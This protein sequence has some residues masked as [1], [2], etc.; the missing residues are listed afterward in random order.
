M[1]KLTTL[2]LLL[3]SPLV[4][5]QDEKVIFSCKHV[6]GVASISVILHLEDEIII[7]VGTDLH[8]TVAWLDDSHIAHFDDTGKVWAWFGVEDGHKIRPA[9]P[10]LGGTLGIAMNRAEVHLDIRRFER[11]VWVSTY[12]ED[13]SFIQ[14][15]LYDNCIN[16]Q[17]L[18]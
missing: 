7:G 15:G 10:E 5:A 1:K 6:S 17:P 9:P 11:E 12:G 18:W 14:Q 16:T 8:P 2:I 4:V 3:L 13:W